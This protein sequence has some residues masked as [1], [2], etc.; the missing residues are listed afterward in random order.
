MPIALHAVRTFAAASRGAYSLEIHSDGSLDELDFA[1]LELAACGLQVRRVEPAERKALLAPQIADKLFS[2]AL[3]ARP[4]YMAKLEVLAYEPGPFFYF[5]SDI[6]WLRPFEPITSPSNKAI[7]SSETWSWYY[8]IQKSGVWIK[9]KIPRRINSGFAYL[10]GEFPF[11]RLEAMLQRGLYTAD[12]WLSTDQELLA[13]LYPDC[14]IFSLLDFA[15]SRR[16]RVYDLPTKQTVAL[17]FPGGMWKDQLT[18]IAQF[19]VDIQQPS[20]PVCAKIPKA[21]SHWEILRMNAALAVE[22]NYLLQRLANLMR[23]TLRGY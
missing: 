2:Q 19:T 23:R 9:E 3:F 6:V 17:H 21:L 16:G 7:F 1:Q 14:R 18:Q 8:G 4:G 15:R 20:C 12:H 10:P 22:Q 13:Y 5:D 11:N